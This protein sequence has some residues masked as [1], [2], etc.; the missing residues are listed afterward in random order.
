MVISPTQLRADLYRLL[1]A[2]IES[3]QPLLVN[4]GGTTLRISVVTPAGTPAPWPPPLRSDLIVGDPDDLVHA[5]W[6]EAWTQGRGL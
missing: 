5:D 1:D 6:S 3:G 4:R 2:V